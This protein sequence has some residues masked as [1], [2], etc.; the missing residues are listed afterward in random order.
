[1]RGALLPLIDPENFEQVAGLT[2]EETALV[3]EQS[4]GSFLMNI[5]PFPAG[6]IMAY[7]DSAFPAG[8]LEC[9]GAY[10][11]QAV[12]AALYAAVGDKFGSGAPSGYF[13]LPD[14]RSRTIVGAR[15]LSEEVP[16][17]SERILGDVG[18]EQA[19]VLTEPELASHFH[20]LGA[21]MVAD[22]AQS[23]TGINIWRRQ[24]GQFPVTTSE[25]DN[26]AHNT[27]PPFGVL[28]WMIFT[29]EFPL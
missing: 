6:A 17:L 4:L 24:A 9:N 15:A 25:G 19:H 1:M 22:V 27:M 2:A 3:F 8:W 20:A 12:Y 14:L 16:G 23:G 10:V 26:V 11:S 28:S 7:P 13:Y 21:G 18:G 29:G 5:L